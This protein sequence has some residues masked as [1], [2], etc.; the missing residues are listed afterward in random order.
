MDAYE[1]DAE[2]KENR[3]VSL[4]E[5]EKQS[6]DE[7]GHKFFATTRNT[8]SSKPLRKNSWIIKD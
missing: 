8:N 1:R 3:S 4:S 5:K 7:F 6:V 2:K